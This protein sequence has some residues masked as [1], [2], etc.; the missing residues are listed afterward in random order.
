MTN[1]RMDQDSV[2]ALWRSFTETSGTHRDRYM[3]DQFADLLLK[4][5]EAGSPAPSEP[6]RQVASVQ[7]GVVNTAA[8]DRATWGAIRPCIVG[9]ASEWRRTYGRGA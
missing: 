1:R 2:D 9:P 6:K 3:V 5:M 8:L 4:A 7:Q